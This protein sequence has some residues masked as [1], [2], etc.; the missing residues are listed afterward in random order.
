MSSGL[1]WPT[2]AAT[3]ALIELLLRVHV[4]ADPSSPADKRRS[5][6]RAIERIR[7]RA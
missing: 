5:C 3:E 2:E 6:F 4:W 1:V 7:R